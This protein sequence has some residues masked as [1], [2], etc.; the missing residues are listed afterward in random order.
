MTA[1]RDLDVDGGDEAP[2]GDP[3]T[4]ADLAYRG[5]VVSFAAGSG[6]G[7]VRTAS[8]RNVPFEVEHCEVA[9]E[10]VVGPRQIALR[11]GQEVGFDLGRTSRGLR[12]TRL[13]AP[14]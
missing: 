6:S 4:P 5:V 9:P 1:P 2:G 8:G 11:P 13:F 14:R 7:V 3:A 12:V 10:F